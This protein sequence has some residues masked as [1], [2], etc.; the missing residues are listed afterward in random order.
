MPETAE[1]QLLSE[2]QNAAENSG[3]GEIISLMCEALTSLQ[4]KD[5]NLTRHMA[6]LSQQYE[7]LQMQLD[8]IGTSTQSIRSQLQ[9]LDKEWLERHKERRSLK[10]EF[11]RD[12]V[13]FF[14]DTNV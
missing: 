6:Q 12:C 13:V 9:N 11:K 1:S 14:R 7:S 10:N 3:C 8:C 2:I 5:Q 4:F